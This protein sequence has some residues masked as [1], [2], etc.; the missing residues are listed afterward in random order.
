MGDYIT[1]L[2]SC[3]V[4]NLQFT[5]R[6]KYYNPPNQKRP[7]AKGAQRRSSKSQPPSAGWTA[8]EPDASTEGISKIDAR[9]HLEGNAGSKNVFPSTALSAL[10]QATI[11]I[12]VQTAVMIGLIFGGCCSNV[13]ALLT[14]FLNLK[15]EEV[16]YGRHRLVLN[17][18][19][20]FSSR[21]GVCA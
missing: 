6:I 18:P 3:V 16:E 2:P 9:P 12:W 19:L 8:N 7:M 20:F 10:A 11:P 4:G 17:L 5:R 14:A 13:R 1:T 21:K 15:A